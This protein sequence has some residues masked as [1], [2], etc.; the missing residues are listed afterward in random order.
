M[1]VVVLYRSNSEHE[2][3]VL[4][5]ERNFEHHAG[6]SIE[7]LDVNTRDGSAMANLYDVVSYPSVL[8]VSNEGSIQYIWDSPTSLPLMNEVMYYTLS[9]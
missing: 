1:R 9:N 2:R 8:A 4:E 6:H 5:F 3:Q 7:L